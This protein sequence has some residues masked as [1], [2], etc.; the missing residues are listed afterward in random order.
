[1]KSRVALAVIVAIG[2]ALRF[3]NISDGLPYRIAVDEPVIAERAIH[4]LRTGNFN[5]GF[6]DY[7]GLFIYLQVLTACVVFMAGAMSG[8]WQS[9]NAFYPEHLFGWTRMLNA[10][11]GTLTIPLV[12]LA[13]RRWGK[14]VGLL[15]A[16][17]L[18]FWA[19]HIR[20]SHFALTDVPLTF[21]VAAAFVLSLRAYESA[22]WSWFAAA[23][24]A[25]GLAAA[26]KYNGANALIVPL[27]AAAV[28][29]ASV[30]AR[31]GYAATAAVSSGGAFLI[32]APYTVL[33]LPAFL[34][35]FAALA[36]Y[37]QP[38][39]F[40]DGAHV[41]LGHLRVAAGW[42]AV[43]ALGIAIVW[44]TV[45]SFRRDDPRRWAIAV[46]FPVLYFYSVSTKQLIFARYLLPNAPFV[47]V[48]LALAVVL[49]LRQVWQLRRPLWQ[50]GAV[51]AAISGVI[52]VPVVRAGVGW[53][54]E[55]GK[56]STQDVAYE[57]IRRVIPRGS[58]VV[59]ERSVLRLPDTLYRE[60][61]IPV[62]VAAP[63]EEYLARDI[64]YVVASSD[65]F[66][67]I[68]A[69]P[70]ERAKQYEAYQRL[71]NAPGHCLTMIQPGR[72]MTGPQIAIC[73]LDAPIE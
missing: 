63:I 59:I 60:I 52:L 33:D 61:N 41:Y 54:R 38:R 71:F 27:I 11:I 32:A 3:W 73:R 12:Y 2:A 25:V 4:I 22:R 29:R 21:F 9:V 47:S 72:D 48:L 70:S 53:P 19:N 24:A 13:G 23:G 15:A 31:A 50:R 28:T 6:F 49:A 66:G 18:A 8:A 7:P 10:T 65:A 55:Y 43:V 26:S 37:Y 64:R 44:G 45:W 40:L 62:F 51:A 39:P 14:D 56:A 36:R 16:A 34:N 5:P 57:R 20:E 67:P 69:R 17:I 42:S 35:A 46:V 30:P 1:M 68:L 58:K